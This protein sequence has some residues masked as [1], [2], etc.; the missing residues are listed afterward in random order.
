MHQPFD[1]PFPCDLPRRDEKGCLLDRLGRVLND[2]LCE[3]CR[4]PT[5][6]PFLK[7][8][9]GKRRCSSC[10]YFWM[11]ALK[12]KPS[13][14]GALGRARRAGLPATLTEEQWQQTLEHFSHLCAYC[15]KKPWRNVEHAT[16]LPSGGTTVD[17]CLPACSVCNALKR[18]KTLEEMVN[19]PNTYSRDAKDWEPA[20][21]WLRSKGRR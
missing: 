10:M 20:L 7:M 12:P 4:E 17:N 1:V 13:L 5:P 9:H 21:A 16:S 14:Q 11:E 19:G 18:G 2:T 6:S 8:F 3:E 15:R